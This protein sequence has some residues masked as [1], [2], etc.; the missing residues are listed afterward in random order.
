V[1]ASALG[2]IPTLESTATLED[3]R[4]EAFALAVDV[5]SDIKNAIRTLRIDGELRP[6]QMK[7][8]KACLAGRDVYVQLATGGGK[9]VIYQVPALVKPTTVVVEP[10]ASLIKDSCVPEV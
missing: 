1:D 8:I 10:S 7:A 9:S 6:D 4:N 2:Q 3:E 5:E